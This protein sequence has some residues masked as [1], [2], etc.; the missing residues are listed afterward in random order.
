M[1]Y[2]TNDFV[3]FF[4]ELAANNH[5]EWFDENRKRYLA[6]VKNP[7]NT[8]VADLITA[9]RNEEPDLLVEPKDCIFRINRD[10]RFSKDKTPYKTQV[11]A[12]ISAGGRKNMSLPGLYLEIN[13]ERIAIYGGIY[14]PDTKL[15][16][17][18]RL[19][20]AGNID[21]FKTAYTNASFIS[22]FS[23]I[24]GEKNKRLDKQLLVA[25]ERE[26]LLYNKQFY[27]YAH[28]PLNLLTT[29]NLVPTILEYYNASTPIRAFLKDAVH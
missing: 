25:A 26:P 3:E 15:L 11:S 6:E 4:K 12:I 14:M 2:F 19:H 10:I 22:K 13:P 20:I 16:K 27:Y 18:V 1:P 29:E 8:L 7:F 5:K 24:Q 17:Q 9:M 23:T 28:L 21:A